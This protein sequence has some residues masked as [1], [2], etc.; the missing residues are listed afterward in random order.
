MIDIIKYI[1]KIIRLKNLL[2]VGLEN[3]GIKYL[4]NSIHD[5]CLTKKNKG[6]VLDVQDLF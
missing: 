6:I 1:Y 4:G 2:K 3:L 5:R